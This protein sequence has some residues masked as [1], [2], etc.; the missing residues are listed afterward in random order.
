MLDITIKPGRAGLNRRGH[1]QKKQTGNVRRHLAH[2][3]PGL[4]QYFANP[5]DHGSRIE[6]RL[7]RKRSPDPGGVAQVA[8][9]F[10]DEPFWRKAGRFLHR[11]PDD[12]AQWEDHV[13]NADQMGNIAQFTP[14]RCRQNLVHAKIDR[15]TSIARKVVAQRREETKVAAHRAF[16]LCR[17]LSIPDLGRM[18]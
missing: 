6:R 13:M 16:E 4:I 7:D 15:V 18:D 17:A 12:R 14:P 10:S 1:F 3:C 9:N 8:A 5:A 11:R 2:E